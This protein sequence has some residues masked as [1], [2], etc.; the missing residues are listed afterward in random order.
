[1]ILFVIIVIL[2]VLLY[3]KDYLRDLSFPFYSSTVIIMHNKPRLVVSLTT[4]PTRIFYIKPV[5]DSIMKQT[6]PAD[7]IYLNLPNVFKRDNTVF[8]KPLP[9]F[10]TKNP[11]IYV[12]WCE[13]FGPITKV[14]PTVPLEKDANTLILSIDDDIE[15]PVNFI[16]T[17]LAFYKAYP[18]ACITGTSYMYYEGN[19]KDKYLLNNY[20]LEGSLV[21][22]VEGYSGVLYHKEFLENINTSWLDEK[23]CKFGDDFYISNELR[24]KN[25]PIIKIGWRYL[26]IMKIKPLEYGFNSDAL[27]KGAGGGNDK[28]YI[29]CSS[30]LEKN[31]ELYIDYYRRKA[32]TTPTPI[33]NVS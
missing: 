5:I 20:G 21:E 15:Y 29:K 23:S 14:L 24:R 3:Y 16:E 1:M 9:D 27:H 30:I 31:N 17:F 22:L 2:L 19:D 6:I 26:P 11:M 8:S 4:S 25:I 28:N 32:T 12:N 13:D 33:V 18:N 10:I 7:R